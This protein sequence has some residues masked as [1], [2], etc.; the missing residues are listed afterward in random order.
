MRSSGRTV[1]SNLLFPGPAPVAVTGRGN[2][3]CP[4]VSITA[5][6]VGS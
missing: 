3:R 1:R 2:C 6:R 5:M 4:C